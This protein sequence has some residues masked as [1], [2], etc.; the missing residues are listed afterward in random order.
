[1]DWEAPP[2]YPA[3]LFGFRVTETRSKTLKEKMECS[4]ACGRESGLRHGWI[5]VFKY[6][7]PRPPT[8]RC[9]SSVLCLGH[10]GEDGTSSSTPSSSLML[11]ERGDRPSPTM[12]ATRPSLTWCLGAVPWHWVGRD[13]LGPPVWPG[14]RQGEGS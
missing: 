10:G 3:G 12:W 11:Q 2:M 13:S 8:Q 4:K 5:Q 7:S 14:H 1:M 6:C 9:A